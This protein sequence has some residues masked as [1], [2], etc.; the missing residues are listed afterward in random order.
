MT[1]DQELPRQPLFWAALALSVGI[2]V[3]AREWRPPAWWAIAVVAFVLAAAWFL[4]RRAWLAKGLAFGVWVLL[5]AFLIQ[6]RG[7]RPDD[8]HI[9][10]LADGRVVTLTGHVMREGYTRTAGPRSIRESID[11]ETQEIADA[12]ERWPV[13]AGIR[14]TIYE[15]LEENRAI[16][17]SGDRI[18]L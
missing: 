3:G 17:P 8:P 6:V 13:R 4:G 9:V 14:L 2:W 16:E 18:S 12:G 11:V 1:R 15:R 10:A 5:G 7:Q